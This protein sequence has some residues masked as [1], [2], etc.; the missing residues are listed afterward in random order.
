[1]QKLTL[2]FAAVLLTGCA[3]VKSWIPSF[4]D[5]NQSASIISVRANIE[6]LDCSQPQLPQAMAIKDQLTW[7]QLYSE[8][9]GWRQADVLRVVAPMQETL[10]D[11]VKRSQDKQGSEA[12]C[13][14]KKKILQTQAK[15]AAAAVLGRF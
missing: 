9:K 1:M 14:I 3:T 15:T 4:W 12:Y 7:F 5:D 2:I 11:F 10:D 8:S 13:N 6:R